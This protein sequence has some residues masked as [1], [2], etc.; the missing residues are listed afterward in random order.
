MSVDESYR[1]VGEDANHRVRKYNNSFITRL[2]CEEI[3]YVILKIPVSLIRK[4]M[5]AYFCHEIAR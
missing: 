1:S 2:T 5:V 4:A 3:L